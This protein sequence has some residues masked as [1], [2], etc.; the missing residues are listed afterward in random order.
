MIVN[1]LMGLGIVPLATEIAKHS[2]PLAGRLQHFKSNWARITQDPWVLKAIQGYR[3]PFSG[4]PYQT[5]PPRALTHSQA[6]EALMQQEIGNMLEKHAIE[7]TT[8]S[9]H[10]FLST[11][12]LVPKKDGGQRPVINLKCLNKFVYTEH[13]KMEG[14][15]ILRDLLRTGDWMTKVDR[16]EGCILH[17][18][19]SR[20]GQSFPQILIQGEDIP[21]QMPA[22]RPSMCPMGLHQDPK[23]TCCSVM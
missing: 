18:T 1:Q 17:G 2:L 14:I 4:Q 16:P 21:I 3:V 5:Y 20:G 9:G 7:E 6:E 22:F 8:P 23:A 13:F 11:I 19:N 15:H 12:F 10:G